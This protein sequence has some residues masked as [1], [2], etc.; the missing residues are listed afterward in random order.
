MPAYIIVEIEIHDP[1]AYEGYKKL[2]L[3]TLKN[4]QGKFIVRGGK[5][6]NLEGEWSPERFVILEFP[7]TD[8]AKKWWA[9]EEYAPAKAIRQSAS[10]TKML[11]V[12]GI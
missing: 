8:L 11:L 3:D 1:E 7:S 12:E 5:T 9:S 2:T 4:Y 6:E 10:A